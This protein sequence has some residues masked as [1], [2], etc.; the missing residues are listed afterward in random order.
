VTGACTAGAGCIVLTADTYT[1]PREL[2][3][4]GEKLQVKRS[5]IRGDVTATPLVTSF[6]LPA[7]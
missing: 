3:Q 2:H 1:N 5:T 7:A 6:Q 4:P